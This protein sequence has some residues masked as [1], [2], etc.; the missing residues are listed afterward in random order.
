MKQ[1]HVARRACI[2]DDLQCNAAMLFSAVDETGLAFVDIAI[3]VQATNIGMTLKELP[4]IGAACAR[5]WRI[6]FEVPMNQAVRARNDQRSAG[7]TRDI[8]EQRVRPTPAGGESG[9]K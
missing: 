7:A 2:L 4:I 1:N 5:R 9:L 6:V 3:G 8:A